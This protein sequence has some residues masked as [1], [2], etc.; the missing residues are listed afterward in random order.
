[1]LRAFARILTGCA[2]QD[3]VVG[4][5]G[6]D[7]FLMLMRTGGQS[8]ALKVADAI[9]RRTREVFSQRNT[10]ISCSIGA[11]GSREGRRGFK[12]IFNAADAALYRAKQKGRNRV[13]AAE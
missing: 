1:M 12:E 11:S 2:P 6:G 5:I 13:E 10:G 9:L 4:R 7:E 8:G 3:A